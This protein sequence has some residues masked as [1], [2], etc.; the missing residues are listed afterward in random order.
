M[1]SLALARELVAFEERD[2]GGRA[3]LSE[4]DRWDRVEGVVDAGDSRE[5]D[6]ADGRVFNLEEDDRDG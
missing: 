4:Q 1:R 6:Q 2:L 5:Q 3:R